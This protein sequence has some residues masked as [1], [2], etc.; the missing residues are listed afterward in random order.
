MIIVDDFIPKSYQEDIKG[1]FLNQVQW[2]YTSDVTFSDMA[3]ESERAPAMAHRFRMMQNTLSPY[4][5]MLLP[6]AYQAADRVGYQ[7]NDVVNCRS[8]LQFPL[9][10]K[11][12]RQEIDP[13]HVDLNRDHLVLLYYVLDSDGDTI[14]IDKQ[15]NS[16]NTKEYDVHVKD[17]EVLAKVTPK[18]GRA[19][20]FDGRYYHTAEQPKANMRCVINFNII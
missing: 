4:F 16:E 8:F 17:Y 15:L 14:L 11:L 1:T 3:K 12:V 5:S 2:G 7:F 10:E 9:N 19:I 20:I 6:M 13:C 18:Q